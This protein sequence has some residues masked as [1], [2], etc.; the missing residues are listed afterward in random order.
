V[1]ASKKRSGWAIAG[2]IIAGLLVFG[3]IS[4]AVGGDETT[5]SSAPIS[6]VDSGTSYEITAE[7]VVDV[8]STTTVTN[9]CNA[10]Y[11]IGD[12]EVGLAQFSEGYTQSNPSAEEVFDELLSRC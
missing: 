2:L 8:M 11:A 10:Y 1:A 4:N 7:D 6:S 9:F 5:A 12:Y 3:W